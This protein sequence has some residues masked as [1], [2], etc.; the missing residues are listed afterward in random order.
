MRSCDYDEE[1]TAKGLQVVAQVIQVPGARE[2]VLACFVPMAVC[3]ISCEVSNAF[4]V[5]VQLL[6][7]GVVH[8]ILTAI[9]THNTSATLVNSCVRT[10]MLVDVV[11]VVDPVIELRSLDMLMSIAK[12]NL[13]MT[14]FLC[15]I[16]EL[17]M[18]WSAN[19][20]L[21]N[22]LLPSLVPFAMAVLMKNSS[23]RGVI[24][25]VLYFFRL[26]ICVIVVLLVHGLCTF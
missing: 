15:N 3:R 14:E 4:G 11:D 17:L 9:D 23:E 5:D 24:I 16:L 8:V 20:E 12:R 13:R 7:A 1:V 25:L 6:A 26:L 2:E 19:A 18:V 21:V 10:L 22:A